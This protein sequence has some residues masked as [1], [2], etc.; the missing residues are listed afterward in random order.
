MLT[1]P[2][3]CSTSS[4]SSPLSRC[5]L[6][7]GFIYSN[8]R[9]PASANNI[10]LFPWCEISKSLNGKPCVPI[11]ND[12]MLSNLMQ[13]GRMNHAVMNGKLKIFSGTTNSALSQEIARYMG[14]DLGCESIAAKLV[15]NLITE[16]GADPVLACDLHFG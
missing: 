16:V 14:L 12:G 6:S 11:I 5:L 8:A 9:I 3:S 13:V 2:S 4:S 15:A 10:V 1:S 7:R